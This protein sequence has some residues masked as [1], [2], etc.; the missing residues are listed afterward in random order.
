MDRQAAWSIL[1][2]FTKT[3]PLRKHA[4]AVEAAMRAYACRY[5]E[6]EE[7]W[8]IVG[9]LHDFDYEVHPNAEEHPLKGAAILRQRGVS[10]EIIYAVLCHADHLGLEG[11]S[12]LDHAIYAVDELAS[13]IIAVALVR[14]KKSIQEVDVTS[15]RK[16]MREK[17]FA[18]NVNRNDIV[19]GAE[20]LGVELDEHIAFVIKA[21]KPVA[22]E[23]GIAGTSP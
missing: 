4:L 5:G 10:E 20:L 2:E 6:D 12:A 11:R 8:G 7:K 22:E 17:G 21:L 18:R 13:F 15:V 14:P 16:K 19:K 1:C 9:L 3:E 23:L